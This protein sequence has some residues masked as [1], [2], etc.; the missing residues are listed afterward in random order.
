MTGQNLVPQGSVAARVC[1]FLQ[2]RSAR[3]YLVGGYVR[4][5]LLGRE[6]HD[7]DFAVEGDALGLARSVADWMH[8]AFVPLD[9]ERGT[10]RAVTRDEHGQRLFVDFAVLQGGDITVDL[11]RRDFTI[12]AIALDISDLSRFIDPYDGRGDLEAGLVRA[13]SEAAFRDDPLRTL[14]A[15]RLA[16]ELSLR[17]EPRTEEWI[18]RDAGL[19]AAVSA[20]RVRDELSKIV[21]QPGAADNLCYLD[22]L[23][24]L[25]V[26]LPET[27]SIKEAGRF[28]R[29]LEVVRALEDLYTIILQPP[30][31]NLQLPTSNLHSDRLLSHLS[32]FTSGDRQRLV[33]LKLVTFLCGGERK[34]RNSA[35]RRVGL[36]LRRLRFSRGEVDLGRAIAAHWGRL[37]RL[38]AAEALTRRDVYRFFRDTGEAGLDLVF[39]FL[40]DQLAAQGVSP[41][42]GQIGAAGLWEEDSKFATALLR[43]Y[44]ERHTEVISPP[45]LIGGGDLMETFGLEEGPRLGEL[46]EAVREAQAAGEIRTRREALDY[47]RGL[48]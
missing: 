8:G 43:D 19:I 23:G 48:L 10:G 2:D 21:A 25:E 24:L 33:L 11:S 34:R 32:Q 22:E 35:A 9:D 6:S 31:S 41:D 14:R 4:D 7:V 39:L 40:A 15:V 28:E 38:R 44:Y 13:V 12:D 36:A 46:L 47:V 29:S 17:I 27:E 37:G 16:A 5:R 3:A 1:R 26:V 42:L 45:K 30:T 20:E 18:R